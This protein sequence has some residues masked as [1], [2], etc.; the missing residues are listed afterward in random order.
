MH[1]FQKHVIPWFFYEKHSQPRG[2]EPYSSFFNSY[3]GKSWR[4]SEKGENGSRFEFYLLNSKAKA[5]L[6]LF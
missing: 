5:P 1:V 4:T 2:F 3:H 6:F